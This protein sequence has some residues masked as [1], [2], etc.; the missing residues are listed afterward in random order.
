M[1][2]RI[3]KGIDRFCS[4]H[5]GGH[6]TIGHLT[7]YGWNA[8]HV[9]ARLWIPKLGMYLCVH[10][11]THTFGGHWPWYVYLSHNAT[12]WGA[13]IGFGPGFYRSDRE[14]SEARWLTLREIHEQL[15]T[16][17]LGK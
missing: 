9:A 8:M 5:I 1:I 16:R 17:D 14:R 2:D 11:T 4:R 15:V 7:I 3:K 6:K 10:P 13:I 12:P